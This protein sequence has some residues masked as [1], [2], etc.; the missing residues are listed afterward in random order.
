MRCLLQLFHTG[1]DKGLSGLTRR[2]TRLALGT[3]A[4]RSGVNPGGPGVRFRTAVTANES[5]CANS[6]RRGFCSPRHG[7][8]ASGGRFGVCAGFPRGD[9]GDTLRTRLYRAA[10]ARSR[11]AMQPTQQEVGHELASRI[12]LYANPFASQHAARLYRTHVSDAH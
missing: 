5:G 3:T 9:K 2:A 7:S 11:T 1:L 8:E 12:T 4:R 6:N 10:P